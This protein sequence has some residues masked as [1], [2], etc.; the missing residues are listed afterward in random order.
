MG[1]LSSIARP[2]FQKIE[3]CAYL[4]SGS[5]VE[6]D[7]KTGLGYLDFSVNWKRKTQTQSFRTRKDI[8][9]HFIW[10]SSFYA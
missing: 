7:F 9:G 5:F 1:L 8:R 10:T 2:L 3:F 6:I 4:L